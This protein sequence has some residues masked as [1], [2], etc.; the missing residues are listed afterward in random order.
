MAVSLR[1]ENK[2]EVHTELRGRRNANRLFCFPLESGT[3]S[4]NCK[5]KLPESQSK[6][7]GS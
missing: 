7:T 6:L 3:D 2:Q 1:K 5:Y 4:P